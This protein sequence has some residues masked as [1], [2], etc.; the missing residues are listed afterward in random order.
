MLQAQ[1]HV[2][3]KSQ[4]HHILSCIAP[5]WGSSSPKPFIL[6]ACKRRYRFAAIIMRPDNG[7]Y[8]CTG[9][10]IH[11]RVV[12]TAAHCVVPAVDGIP[13]PI[14][15]M[16]R[17]GVNDAAVNGLSSLIATSVATERHTQTRCVL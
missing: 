1:E 12:L 15:V 6:L 13:N 11:P 16:G 9:S 17:A 10:L 14:V 2:C 4:L 5:I 3:T 8:L 7:K